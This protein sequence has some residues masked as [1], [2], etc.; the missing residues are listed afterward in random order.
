MEKIF[1]V[2]IDHEAGSNLGYTY[3]RCGS[4]TAAKIAGIKEYAK[5]GVYLVSLYPQRTR[6][7]MHRTHVYRGKNW[8]TGDNLRRSERPS[9]LP[10]INAL[11]KVQNL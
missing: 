9:I 8:I 10:L 4:L 3:M 6:K 11:G 2:E 5:G 1:W 7:N